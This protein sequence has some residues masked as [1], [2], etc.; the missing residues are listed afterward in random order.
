MRVAV[1]DDGLDFLAHAKALLAAWHP[2]VDTLITE[3][4]EDGDAL[5][6]AH[7]SAPFD[8]ILLDVVMPLL[9]GIEA[10]REIR[11][12]DKSVR[13]VFLTSSPEFAVDSYSVKASN[14]LLK[15]LDAEKL[16]RCLDEIAEELQQNARS[17]T[18]KGVNVVQRV[19]LSRIEYVE[20][21]NKHVLFFLTDGK[22]VLS[23]EPFYVYE[24]SLFLEGGFFKCHRSYL[25]NIHKIQ[26]FTP[27]E[28]TM[29]SGA[30]IPIS[31]GCHKEFES[32]YFAT[33]FGKAG[34]L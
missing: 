34:D 5:I 14:Y 24:Q 3:F 29:N 26:T 6:Q 18:V 27:K 2:P 20:A 15:P 13:I 16:Y 23:T 17:I 12:H 8:I 31:R 9:N 21:Q 25:V 28:I 7:A 32:A 33:L 1:C 4:F 10:A 22:T 19:E 30:R 11:Q